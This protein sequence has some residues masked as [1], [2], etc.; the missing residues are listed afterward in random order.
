LAGRVRKGKRHKPATCGQ[1]L[2]EHIRPNGAV[3]R[4]P[5]S[6]LLELAARLEGQDA[7]LRAELAETREQLEQIQNDAVSEK[8]RTAAEQA[9]EIAEVREAAQREILGLRERLAESLRNTAAQDEEIRMLRRGLTD[10]AEQLRAAQL[11][12]AEVPV[13]RRALA[14]TTKK[15]QSAEQE[16]QQIPALKMSLRDAQAR[17]AEQAL[18]AVWPVF[19][20]QIPAERDRRVRFFADHGHFLRMLANMLEREAA[21]PHG[22]SDRHTLEPDALVSRVR[23][24]FP[25][26]HAEPMAKPPRLTAE[27]GRLLTLVAQALEQHRRGVLRSAA[28]SFTPESPPGSAP[29]YPLR[30]EPLHCRTIS[31]FDLN[32]STSG[33]TY[34]LTMHLS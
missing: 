5:L 33:R 8:Q 19:V 31:H 20:E 34:Q 16:L 1:T 29:S 6:A 11:Q 13:L 9:R 27:N 17:L 23:Q 21:N 3:E 22:S 30:L 12:A 32:S 26:D 10:A 25:L 2:L 24:Y 15:L 7:E 4:R 18:Q 28:G 14:D